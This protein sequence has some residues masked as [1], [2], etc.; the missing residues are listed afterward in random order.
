MWYFGFVR[1]Q[2]IHQ[3]EA[4]Q[5]V[6]IGINAIRHRGPDGDGI[7]L[8]QCGLSALG[9]TRLAIIDADTGQQPM[10]SGCGRYVVFNGEIY[11]Y[12]EL[13]NEIG[14][15]NF[16]TLS[17]TEVIIEAFKMWGI[18]CLEKFSACFHLQYGI[19]NTKASS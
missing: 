19:K 17:D 16:K 4:L 10:V 15:G 11:N 6:E 12:I 2:P 3:S 1:K 8:S 9:H 5:T 14:R 13:R 7:W 18:E